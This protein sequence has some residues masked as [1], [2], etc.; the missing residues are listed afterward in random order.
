VLLPLALC[1]RDGTLSAGFS[2]L[3]DGQEVLR[4]SD[5]SQ[6]QQADDTSGP[7]DGFI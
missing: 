3:M 1:R 7:S 4:E 2:R 5:G 6:G